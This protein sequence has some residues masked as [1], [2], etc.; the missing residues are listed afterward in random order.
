MYGSSYGTRQYDPALY[1]ALIEYL[2]SG[3]KPIKP[4]SPQTFEFET[5]K[6]RTKQPIRQPIRQ[7]PEKPRQPASP[8]YKTT[9][10]IP[11][12]V[13]RPRPQPSSLGSSFPET[14]VATSFLPQSPREN[15]PMI[16]VPQS[17]LKDATV[18][19]M[20]LLKREWQSTP[21]P[22]RTA[23][24][25]IPTPEGLQTLQQLR[26]IYNPASLQPKIPVPL[27]L[28]SGK[29]RENTPRRTLAKFETTDQMYQR[30]FRSRNKP[31]TPT[32]TYTPSWE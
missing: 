10:S 26:A 16:D 15:L 8:R 30:V 32:S 3:E 29:S 17:Q 12:F 27:K 23:Q 20:R 18:K 6:P 9:R 24:I 13:S 22:E 25:Q 31:A 4:I 28:F 11:T 7:P 5:S 19:M 14:P 2:Q 1:K 21:L